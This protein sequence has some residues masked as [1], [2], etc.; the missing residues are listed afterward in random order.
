M[1]GKEKEKAS[2]SSSSS[3][4][5]PTL[6]SSSSEEEEKK[7]RRRIEGVLSSLPPTLR[8]ALIKEVEG[9]VFGDTSDPVGRSGWVVEKKREKKQHVYIH[10]L[11]HPPTHPPT[12]SLCRTLSPSPFTTAWW[13][14]DILS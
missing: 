4:H 10:V 2:S 12:F 13:I 11:T 9:A 6:S 7:R 1:G 14:R 5:P 3:S 8:V